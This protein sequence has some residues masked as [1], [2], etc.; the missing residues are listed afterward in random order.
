MNVNKLAQSLAN[1][2]SQNDRD[3]GIE[4]TMKFIVSQKEISE[5]DFAKLWQGLYYCYWLADKQMYQDDICDTFGDTLL[6]MQ[7]KNALLYLKTFYANILSNW[8][9][10]DKHRTAKFLTLIRKFTQITLQFLKKRKYSLTDIS[11]VTDILTNGPFNSDK[12]L[13]DGLKIYMS[14]IILTEI[15]NHAINFPANALFEFLKPYFVVFGTTYSG[16]VIKRMTEEFILPTIDWRAENATYVSKTIDFDKVAQIFADLEVKEPRDSKARCK[17]WKMEFRY[18]QIERTGKSVFGTFFE[19]LYGKRKRSDDNVVNKVVKT[20][21][22][23]KPNTKHVVPVVETPVMTKNGKQNG[24]TEKI[25]STPV[26]AVPKEV[27][28]TPID[29]KVPTPVIGVKSTPVEKKVAQKPVKVPSPVLPVKDLT[30]K[31]SKIAKPKI[32]VTPTENKSAFKEKA[33]PITPISQIETPIKSRK[34]R[35]TQPTEVKKTIDFGD[36]K[37][38]KASPKV[39]PVV[40]EPVPLPEREG[41]PPPNS[42]DEEDAPIRRTPLRTRKPIDRITPATIAAQNRKSVRIDLGKNQTKTF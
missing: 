21:A 37:G 30:P 25:V 27:K 32:V 11:E 5:I 23:S 17:N 40:S 7:P 26:V 28:S 29:K 18:A 3:V 13:T 35:V 4:N 39:T 31:E 14:E 2:V 1:S 19:D 36:K 22:E 8:V 41:S 20:T 6:A 12:S 33:S 24:K 9:N 38:K 16:G 42:K 15:E 10:L 34:A